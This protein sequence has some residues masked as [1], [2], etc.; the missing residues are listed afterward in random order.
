MKKVKVIKG[1]KVL[2]I[3]GKDRGKTGVV[4][5]VFPNSEKVVVGGAN[6]LKKHLKKSPKNPQGGIIDIT[7]PIHISNVMLLDPSSNKP[8]RIGYM[9]KGKEKMRLSRLSGEAI[10]REK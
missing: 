4:E 8:T 3:A 2:V 10:R 7:A 6:I 1:D 5:R 9:V